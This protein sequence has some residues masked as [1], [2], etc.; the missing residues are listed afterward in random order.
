[1]TIRS[2]MM[3]K[4]NLMQTMSMAKPMAPLLSGPLASVLGPIL[5]MLDPIIARSIKM[6][7]VN[8]D[9]EF[10]QDKDLIKPLLTV[11]GLF[12]NHYNSVYKSEKNGKKMIWVNMPTPNE[13]PYALGI[14]ACSTEVF[15]VLESATGVATKTFEGTESFGISRDGCSFD[16][17]LIG[18]C[19]LGKIPPGDAFTSFMAAGCDSQGE[20]AHRS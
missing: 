8:I 10:K 9:I 16:S 15:G 11:A 6:M 1:M 12:I 18:A 13:I 4:M 5:P 7:D 14:I 17:H 20:A 3:S 2:K 19:D